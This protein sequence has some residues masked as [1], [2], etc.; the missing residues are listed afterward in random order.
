MERP[1]E[2]IDGIVVTGYIW[3][4]EKRIPV[5]PLLYDR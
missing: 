1:V 3:E 5:I 4:G 2:P